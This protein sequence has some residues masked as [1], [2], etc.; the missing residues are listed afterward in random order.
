MKGYLLTCVIFGVEM[1]M[2]GY[3]GARIYVQRRR[4]RERTTI[5]LL[6]LVAAHSTFTVHR[7]APPFFAECGIIPTS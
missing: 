6:Y 7:T 2:H 1:G 3:G 5:M 4:E